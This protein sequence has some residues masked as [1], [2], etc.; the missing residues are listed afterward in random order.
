MH[1]TAIIAAAGAGRRLGAS[2][3]KQLIDIGGGTMLQHSVAAFHRHPRIDDIVVVL[4]KGTAASFQL[5][6]GGGRPAP[7][8]RTTAGGERR[9]DSVA[10]AFELVGE[11]TDIVLIHD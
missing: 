6:A 7:R 5:D 4:P 11:E 10:N 9:Q 3:P 2:T 8:L 1:V